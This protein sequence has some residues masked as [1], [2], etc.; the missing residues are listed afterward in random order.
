MFEKQFDHQL[1]SIHS[2]NGG[3]YTPVERYAKQHGIAVTRLAPYTLQSNGIAERMNRTLIEAVRTTLLQSGLPK[4]FWAESLANAVAVQNRV[5]ARDSKSPY[6]ALIGMKPNLER[7]KP[8]GCLAMAHLH[9]NK[10]RKLD[11]KVLPCVLLRTMEHRNYR[12]LD[13]KNSQ[14]NVARH[15][16]FDEKR[17]PGQD[18]YFGCETRQSDTPD[19]DKT[20]W[21]HG[22]DAESLENDTS[23]HGVSA[24]EDTQSSPSSD[25]DENSNEQHNDAD[26]GDAEAI[27]DIG[28]DGESGNDEAQ[29]S[30]EPDTHTRTAQSHYPTRSR[31]PPGNWWLSSSVAQ[32]NACHGA[33]IQVNVPAT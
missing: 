29:S 32:V 30:T 22:N 7:F 1:K 33:P 8:F 18:K 5:P 17:F 21:E 31:R 9:E 20:A 27:D 23:E 28:S 24:H 6:E 3:K 11:A 10:R 14:V 13:L 4:S 26:G 15:V 16:T 25:T 19:I 2:D 12:L